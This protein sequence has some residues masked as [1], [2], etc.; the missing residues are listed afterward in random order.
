[1]GSAVNCPSLLQGKVSALL[2]VLGNGVQS[3]FSKSHSLYR[4]A[5]LLL[6]EGIDLGHPWQQVVCL[7]SSLSPGQADRCMSHSPPPC[8]V[9]SKPPSWQSCGR[10]ATALQD[11]GKHEQQE[12]GQDISSAG[13]GMLPSAVHLLLHGRVQFVSWAE[14][15]LLP[16]FCRAGAAARSSLAPC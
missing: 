8:F 2:V 9:L 6:E 7:H 3:T 4:L 15:R 1:M 13:T 14:A 5:R 16:S 12:G 11:R 10:A